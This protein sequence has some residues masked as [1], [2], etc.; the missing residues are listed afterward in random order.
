MDV[1]LQVSDLNV[2]LLDT[3]MIFTSVTCTLLAAMFSTV[4]KTYN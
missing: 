1:Q 2:L 4:F 3:H